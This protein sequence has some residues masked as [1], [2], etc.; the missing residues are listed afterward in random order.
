MIWEGLRVMTNKYES[1][2]CVCVCVCVCVLVCGIISS[3]CG[4]FWRA[5]QIWAQFL[6]NSAGYFTQCVQCSHLFK[7]LFTHSLIHSHNTNLVTFHTT[8]VCV[9]KLHMS[10]QATSYSTCVMQYACVFCLKLCL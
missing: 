6:P 5:K 1:G 8:Y 10:I 3:A 4:K 7:H 9:F 2:C